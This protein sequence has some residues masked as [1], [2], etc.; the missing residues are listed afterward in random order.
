LGD[1]KIEKKK[2]FRSFCV[3][4]HLVFEKKIKNFFFEKLWPLKLFK[5]QNGT[6]LH[7]K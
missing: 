3:F 4:F 6:F 1:Q 2:L 7:K 5:R